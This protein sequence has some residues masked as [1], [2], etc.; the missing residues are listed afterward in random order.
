MSF[1][2]IIK[3]NSALVLFI[4][5]AVISFIL[6]NSEFK[7]FANSKSHSVII[8]ITTL[9]FIMIVHICISSRNYF[10]IVIGALFLFS[11]F[12][13]ISYFLFYG[14]IISESVLDS[15]VE[16][17]SFEIVSMFKSALI[18]V[19]PAIILTFLALFIFNKVIHVKFSIIIPLTFYIACFSFAISTINNSA[20]LNEIKKGYYRGGASYIIQLYP[21]VLGNTIY[22]IVSFLTTDLYS[23]TNTIEKF[24]ESVILPPDE[25]N[26]N[27]IILIMGE[28]SLSK[29]YSTYGYHKQTTPFMTEIFSQN[30]G[31]IINNS[32]SSASLTRDSIAMTLSFNEPESDDNLFNN[33]SII[34][35]AKFNNYKTYWLGSQAIKGTFN[36]KYGFIARKSD[37]VT[38]S[39]KGDINLNKLLEKN[40]KEDSTHKKLFFIHLRGNHKP[41]DNYDQLDRQA[42]P[43]ADDYDLTIHHTDRVVKSLYDTIRQHSNNFTLIYTS[44]HG[45]NVNIGTGHGMMK[46]VDQFLIP[47]MFISTNSKYDCQFIESFRGTTGYLSG[48]MN[49][50]IISILL[51]YKI[52][53]AFIN[54]EKANDRVYMPNGKVI[55]FAKIEPLTVTP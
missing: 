38:L 53:Q 11:F 34:E 50:Y 27:L 26:N 32:H 9:C 3:K 20:I 41:Y 19:V 1:H 35:L 47:Y 12:S 16:T 55:P 43:D 36:T 14:E 49:K 22:L 18:I 17:N 23:N 24:N 2:Q 5:Y 29:R 39:D 10:I 37:I 6:V 31:C 40:L 21:T 54:K 7:D 13:E 25:S 33:K 45:E 46:G 28:S 4:I 42:L 51:G 48:L 44:D 30:N 15:I 8:Y 52:D